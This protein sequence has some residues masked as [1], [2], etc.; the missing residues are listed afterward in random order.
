[1]GRKGE[2]KQRK[3]KKG[4][5][6]REQGEGKQPFFYSESGI[7][8][9]CQVTAGQSLDRML[10]LSLKLLPVY[11]ICSPNLAVLSGLSGRSA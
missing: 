3:N 2:G 10:T 7:P 11:G 6:A 5:R 8:G 9:Y 4:A 1:M